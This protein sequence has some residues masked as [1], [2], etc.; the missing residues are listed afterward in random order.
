VLILLVATYLIAALMLPVT[1][2]R[3][4]AGAVLLAVALLVSSQFLIPGARYDLA[5]EMQY[6]TGRAF[7]NLVRAFAIDVAQI[8]GTKTPDAD[9][10]EP[11]ASWVVHRKG[12][13]ERQK[14]GDAGRHVVTLRAA[15]TIDY[16]T[17]LPSWFHRPGD[18]LAMKAGF[19][20]IGPAQAWI[21]LSQGPRVAKA[22]HPGGATW[23][24]LHV[25]LVAGSG[26]VAADIAVVGGAHATV[27]DVR[28]TNGRG[29]LTLL[30]RDM[31]EWLPAGWTLAKPSDSSEYVP[32]SRYPGGSEGVLLRAVGAPL[33]FRRTIAPA[34]LPQAEMTI[35]ATLRTTH[36]ASL[37]VSG[38]SGVVETR[39]AART[40]KWETLTVA[41]RRPV[42]DPLAVTV[43]VVSGGEVLLADVTASAPGFAS[44]LLHDGVVEDFQTE[45]LDFPSAPIAIGRSRVAQPAVSTDRTPLGRIWVMLVG[46]GAEFGMW[47]QVFFRTTEPEDYAVATYSDTKYL[48]FAQQFGLIGLI[49][50]VAVG[51]LAL[52]QCGRLSYKARSLDVRAH[53]VG[54]G[55]I[56][57]ITY[58]SLVHLPSLFRVGFGTVFFIAI[59]AVS[60]RGV[61]QADASPA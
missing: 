57:L 23:H 8:T 43:S 59:A 25:A 31:P 21:E 14:E 19:H 6:L 16:R 58:I 26:T 4:A 44:S 3:R 40:G 33:G 5:G 9:V 52:W 32:L 46:R 27:R 11:A 54:L 2:G 1:W 36:A 35:S 22:E 38:Q 56:V 24:E 15:E 60:R 61:A 47:N 10:P 7:P 45:R 17:T 13:A 29:T 51:A 49:A 30:G 20:A 39:E 28:I 42:V 53:V 18:R 48:E 55:L 37:Q 50:L 34:D 12:Q 41:T